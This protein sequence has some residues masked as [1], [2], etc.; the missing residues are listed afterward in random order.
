MY[1]IGE[2]MRR[3]S[4]YILLILFIFSILSINTTNAPSGTTISVDPILIQDNQLK[5]GAADTNSYP[6][7]HAETATVTNP[8]YAYDKNKVTFALVSPTISTSFQYFD[9]KAFNATTIKSYSCINI[10]MNYSV[11]IYKAYYKMTLLV[12]STSYALQFQ[13]STNVTTPTLKTWTALIEPNDGLWNATDL[14]NL[15]I[16]VEVKKLSSTGTFSCQFKEYEA[17]ATIQG[18]SF[19]FRVNVSDV[20]VPP[21]DCVAWGI[22]ITF[23]PLVL[24]C[25]TVNEGAFLKQVGP[26]FFPAVHIDNQ[27]GLVSAGASLQDPDSGGATGGGFLATVAFKVITQGNS[28]LAFSTIGTDLRWWDGIVLHPIPYTTADGYFR[29]IQGDVNG[30]TKV[31]ALDL[32][33]L[34]RAYGS[35]PAQPTKWNVNCDF[36]KDNVINNADLV[37]LK[38]NYG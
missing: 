28:V 4:V 15:I 25:L 26:T 31:N 20:P 3:E 21:N 9:V 16:R 37:T 19:T 17:W 38:Q 35:T 23:N 34:G 18:D 10:N 13:S 1:N 11:T 33:L 6:S 32:Y 24:Q 29:S 2:S 8:T 22:N 36:N 27:I 5:P 12:G 7:A 30:D 14:N